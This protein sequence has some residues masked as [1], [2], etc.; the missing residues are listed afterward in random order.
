MQYK[1]VYVTAKKRE[2]IW[3]C[4]GYDFCSDDMKIMFL[5]MMIVIHA[6][7]ALHLEFCWLKS[8][9]AQDMCPQNT[10][11]DA[12]LC[13]EINMDGFKYYKYTLL[14]INDV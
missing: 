12:Y 7:V 13:P 3:I 14:Y 11:H 4:A 5:M 10:N 1:N 2:K 8:W 6:P 9:M